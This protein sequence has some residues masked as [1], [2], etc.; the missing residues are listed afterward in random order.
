MQARYSICFS[1]LT[2]EH[3]V[4]VPGGV[5]ADCHAGRDAVERVLEDLR[6]GVPAAAQHGK[7]ARTN[8]YT[9]L[10]ATI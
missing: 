3:S 10:N 2:S 8:H 5:T 9:N 7:G 6:L 1:F 4:A